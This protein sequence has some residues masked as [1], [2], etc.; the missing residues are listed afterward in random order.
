MTYDGE[1]GGVT[2]TGQ[3]QERRRP[4]AAWGLP[5]FKGILYP[6]G[7]RAGGYGYFLSKQPKP[8][9]YTGES[10]NVLLIGEP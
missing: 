7:S 5:E 9:D 1:S 4:R 2:L 6:R 3:P 10:G 8:I